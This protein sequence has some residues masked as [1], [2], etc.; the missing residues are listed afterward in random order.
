MMLYKVSLCSRYR[1][2]FP[3]HSECSRPLRVRVPSGLKSLYK[4]GSNEPGKHDLQDR[5]RHRQTSFESDSRHS[6]VRLFQNSFKT[7]SH[8]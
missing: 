7:E 5:Q 1:R 4:L 2:N 3:V 8:K 6:T